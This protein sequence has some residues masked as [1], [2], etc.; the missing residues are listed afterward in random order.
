M[1]KTMNNLETEM[2]INNS[3]NNNTGFRFV[4]LE[5]LNWGTFNDSIWKIEPNE[6]NSLLTGDIG[7]GKST[8]VDA[9]TTLLVPH[10]K[11]TYNKRRVL[12]VKKEIFTHISE[13]SIKVKKMK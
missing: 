3:N 1:Q 7:A 12:K 6:F 13:V 2:T 11:I 8:L 5:V 10:Q 4:R 9:I